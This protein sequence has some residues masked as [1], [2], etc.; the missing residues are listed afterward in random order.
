VLDE[1]LRQAAQRLEEEGKHRAVLESRV[2]QEE[3]HR[4][5]LESR[6]TELNLRRSQHRKLAED[7]RSAKA[8]AEQDLLAAKEQ[9]KKDIHNLKKRAETGEIWSFVSLLESRLGRLVPVQRG[10]TTWS[11]K[12]TAAVGDE[13]AFAAAEALRIGAVVT[14]DL[15]GCG[16]R[17]PGAEA[18]AEALRAN[19]TLRTLTLTGN[20]LGDAGVAALAAALH[21]NTALTTLTLDGN[22]FGNAGVIALAAALKANRTLRSLSF[23]G[24][25]FGDESAAEF[26]EALAANTAIETLAFNAAYLSNA[27]PDAVKSH[28]SLLHLECDGTTFFRTSPSGPWLGQSTTG[29]TTPPP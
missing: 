27:V 26:A 9:A 20:A 3:R 17:L 11:F 2:Q 18:L 4:A 12:G 24:N 13:A 22:S 7:L 28:R 15:T 23:K 8:R 19:T 1:R 5:R 25:S 6:V 16:I 14:M 10:V 29:H 21:P